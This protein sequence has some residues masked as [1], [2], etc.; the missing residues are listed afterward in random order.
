MEYNLLQ[1]SEGRLHKGIVC[2]IK[3]TY[4]M[5]KKMVG[6]KKKCID[7]F[8][9]VQKHNKNLLI[10]INCRGKIRNVDVS[11]WMCDYLMENE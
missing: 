3:V 1:K 7:C 2:K 11:V 9:E 6:I 4:N 5:N 10:L 8:M